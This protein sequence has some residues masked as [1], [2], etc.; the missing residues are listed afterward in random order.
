MFVVR[1]DPKNP[2]VAPSAKEQWR[3]RAAFNPSIVS[4]GDSAALYFRAVPEAS[5]V[6]APFATGSLIG[7]ALSENAG[8]TFAEPEVAL[9]PKEAWEA[10]GMED[11]RAT[12][13][14]GRLYLTYTALGGYPYSAENIKAAIAVSDD[15]VT[16]SERHLMTP[17]NAKAFALF[18]RKV[19]GKYAAFLTAHTDFTPEYPRPVIALA[20]ASRIEDFWDPAYWKEWH[21]E[22]P[23]HA[24]P[25]LRRSDKDHIEVG[26]S[27]I[28]T[29]DGWLLIYSYISHYYD[30]SRR[31]F[32][33]EALLL[34]HDD[35]KKVLGRTYPFLTPEMPYEL[36]GMVPNIV[37]PSSAAVR[38][39]MLD[40]YYGGADTVCARASM[41]LSDLLDTLTGRAPAFARARENPILLPIPENPFESKLVFNPAAFELDGSVQVIYRAMDEANT[42]MFGYARSKDG[43]H[44][45]ERLPVPIYGPRADFELK[46]GKPDGNSGVEDPRT[47]IIDDRLY[48][49]YTAYDGV[50]VPHGAISS[51]SLDDFR[52]RQF[53]NWTEP[54]L[55][56]ADDVDDKDVALLPEKVKGGYLLYHRVSGRICADILPDLEFAQRAHECIDVF[57]PRP[58][59]WDSAKVG[60]S[61]PPIRVPRGWLMLYHGVSED[62]VY[63]VGAALLAED[64]ITLLA[65]AADPV[66]EPVEQYEREGEVPDVVFPCGA[67]VRDGTLYLY[68]GGAD[69]VVGVATAPLSPIIDA[70]S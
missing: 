49:T 24:L 28:Y 38:G 30:E 58:G 16:F 62:A 61:C 4:D 6:I 32:G 27:P 60:I 39:E 1:R 54:K 48:L 31:S 66:F 65:R 19:G 42:S 67:V 9:R 34:D 37:F 12:K 18:P 55:M 21:T 70:L 13:L 14:D 52:A 25:N 5:P 8:E 51:L 69:K 41:R 35:P 23:S 40:V 29:D 44:I 15:G 17:F 45:D 3:A 26:A 57:G 46:R 56:T 33:I 63:R 53:Q 68:Y 59:M 11:P 2:L 20:L 47:V 43:V 7:R 50:H 10:F 22:L 36:N 64:G